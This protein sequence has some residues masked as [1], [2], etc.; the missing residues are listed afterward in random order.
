[1]WQHAWSRLLRC[2][3]AA[4]K[5][6]KANTTLKFLRLGNNEVGNEGAAALAEAVKATVFDVWFGIARAK[7]P[8]MLLRGQ[9]SRAGVSMF[10]AKRAV[11]PFCSYL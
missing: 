7:F 8:Q 9:A 3:V 6:C 10:F 5:Q 2:A 1:M 11:Q 4:V